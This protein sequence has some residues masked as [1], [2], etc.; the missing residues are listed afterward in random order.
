M[1]RLMKKIEGQIDRDIERIDGLKIWEDTNSWILLRPSGT[2]PV[3]RVFAESNKKSKLEKMITEY[4]D[5]V[6]D[7]LSKQKN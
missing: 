4:S 2:E 3:F 1:P 6:K 7:A 5:L